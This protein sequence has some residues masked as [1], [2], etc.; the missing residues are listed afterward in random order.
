MLSHI[1]IC[2]DYCTSGQAEEQV[3]FNDSGVTRRKGVLVKR[4][5]LQVWMPERVHELVP[6]VFFP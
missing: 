4:D 5:S 3:E 6:Q 2:F 1:R